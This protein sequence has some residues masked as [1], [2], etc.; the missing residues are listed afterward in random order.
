MNRKAVSAVLAAVF[1][2][3]LSGA[4]GRSTLTVELKNLKIEG[5][6]YI[7]L[8]NKEDGYPMDSNKAFAKNMKKVTANTEKIVFNDVPYGTYAVSVWHDQN[9][10]QKMEKSLIGIPKEGLGVSNDAKGKMG[11]PKF[12]DA[13]FEVK[14]EKTDISI[15]VKY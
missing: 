11:P 7:T 6:V 12:K 4:D 10:N 3:S 15:T 2:F 1:F 13:K 8:Y 14:Q 9:D 5:T